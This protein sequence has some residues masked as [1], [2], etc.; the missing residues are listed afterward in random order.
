MGNNIHPAVQPR[1]TSESAARPPQSRKVKAI[2]VV[3][4]ALGA[5]YAVWHGVSYQRES[6]RQLRQALADANAAPATILKTVQATPPPSLTL[7]PQERESMAPQAKEI[8]SRL[9][10]RRDDFDGSSMY[11]AP[12]KS[13]T[14]HQDVLYP[15]EPYTH[16]TLFTYDKSPSDPGLYWSITYLADEWLFVEEY[17]IKVDD[18]KPVNLTTTEEVNRDHSD[19]TV[20]ERIFMNA[21]EQAALLDRLFAGQKATIRIG[22]KKGYHDIEIN[23]AKIQEMKEM[24]FVYRA[25]GGRWPS[26]V[27]TP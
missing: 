22:G 7:P 21:C 5:V 15:D 8:I 11:Q 16:M 12:Y 1:R 20:T 25:L 26:T 9:K 24:F 2:I 23:T 14:G 13:T 19:G 18:D 17:T 27:A 10:A 3:L 6:E 4:A